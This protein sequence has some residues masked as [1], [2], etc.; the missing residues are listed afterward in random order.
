LDGGNPRNTFAQTNNAAAEIVGYWGFQEVRHG[1]V[2]DVQGNITSFD[3]P[4]AGSTPGGFQGT[5]GYA[6]NDGGD[7]TGEYIDGNNVQ[8]GF[9][10]TK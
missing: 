5:Y 3:V 1:F 10:L 9:L 7:I 8:H 2:R 4:G 6:N